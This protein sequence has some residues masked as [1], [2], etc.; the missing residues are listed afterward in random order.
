MEYISHLGEILER[1]MK[2]NR[3]LIWNDGMCCEGDTGWFL[4]MEPNV[5]FK[6]DLINGSYEV[7]TSF[8]DYSIG[9][10]E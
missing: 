1:K 4:G 3:E 8:S 2:E 10:W 7:A 9:E 6:S 5:L